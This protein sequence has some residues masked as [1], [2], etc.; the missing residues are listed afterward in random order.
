MKTNLTF[1]AV[2]FFLVSCQNKDVLSV[3]SSSSDMRFSELS[4]TWDEGIPL[5]NAFVGALVWQKDSN[6]RFSLDRVDLWDLRPTDSLSG[7]NFRFAWVQEQVKKN[8]YLLVQK[9]LDWSYDRE[10]AP[11]KIP[12]AAL[13]FPLKFFGELSHI[14]LHI[15]NA[16]CVA[17][18][19]N[20]ITMKTFVH[21]SEPVGWFVF[22]NLPDS[23]LPHLVAP[24]Y[25]IAQNLAPS[26]VVGGQDL[27]RLNYQQGSIINDRQSIHYHQQGWGD[28]YYDVSVKWQQNGS[29]LLGVWSITSSL[30][31][32]SSEDLVSKAMQRNIYQDYQNHLNYWN[33]YWQKSSVSLP[34]SILQ[35][36]Y[37]LEMYKFASV[38]RENSYPISLQA[39]WTADN[40][41][42][43]PWKG[44]F[45]HDLNTQ[46]SYWCTYI[47]NHLPEGLGIVNTLWK[48]R[49]V[50]KKYTKQYFETEGLNVP[51]VATLM[52]EPMGGWIQYAL[53]PTCAAW[54]SHSFYQH[55]KFSA[56]TV[57]LEQQA[58]PFLKDVALYLEQIS[59]INENGIR[60]L[61]I[62]SSPEIFDNSINAWFTTMTNYDLALMR[63]LFQATSE[64][65]KVLNL[66]EEAE[67]WS[68]IFQQLP[69]FDTDSSGSLTFAKGFPYHQSHRHFSH[70]LAIY[71]LGLLDVHD[72]DQSKQIV[73]S[74]LQQLESFGTDGWTGYSFAWYA[75]M[76]ARALHGDKAADALRSFA[77]CFCLRNSFH[78]NG[79]QN[80]CGKS[81]FDYRPFTLEGNFAFASA[82]QEML[83]QSHSGVIRIFPAVPNDWKNI[84]FRQLRAVNAF[85]ISAQKQDGKISQIDIFAEKGGRC[86]LALPDLN[87]S[88]SGNSQPSTLENNVVVFNMK[89]GETIQ[90]TF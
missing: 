40:G 74:T 79:D 8:D 76:Q 26:D 44:D 65:A 63:F 16:L 42:L 51:G 11:S 19:K 61:P 38:T 21:A 9:K 88:I 85:L 32:E 12:G 84:S 43:P 53:S 15:N 83:L 24:S 14:Q 56:D 60:Q 34:D 82:I 45:H 50:Y 33:Q 27:R 2:L 48:Q 87:F 29:T 30:C 75:N 3:K 28:F 90:L 66:N 6:L 18:W 41:K 67:H 86:R 62:S 72:G 58:Y 23:L 49:D 55:W 89:K 57:F 37:D 46:M 81:K 17:T 5:G 70:A 69:D 80:Q 25:Q 1:L 47:G 36:Q 78:A 22:E 52:G 7:E 64:M 73:E 77:E 39:V 59:V 10:P 68:K 71:P 20:G 35:K 31:E 54:L 13:E 4:T